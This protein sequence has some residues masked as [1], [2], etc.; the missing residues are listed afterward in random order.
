MVY[1]LQKAGFLKRTAAWLLD[2]ILVSILAVGIAWILSAA[3][4]YDE[5]S[6]RVNDAYDRYEDQ[7]GISFSSSQEEYLTWT[8]EERQNYDRAYEALISDEDAMY[9]YNM[10]VNLSMLIASLS[11]LAAVM[12]LEFAVPVLFKE[13][14]TVG[15]RVFGLSVVRSDCVRMSTVQLFVRTLLGKFAVETMIPI[16]LIMMIFWGMI[17]SGGTLILLVLLLAQIIALVATRR[18]A[19]IHDLLAGTAVVDY[20]SQMVFDSPEALLAYQKKIH[21]ELAARQDY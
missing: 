12:G 6:D 9:A 19:A 17:G 14:R 15:K 13:G 8:E 18:N 21:A 16:Y 1:E 4:G 11:I 7:Y 5:Y 20:A 3:L 10:V 2:A